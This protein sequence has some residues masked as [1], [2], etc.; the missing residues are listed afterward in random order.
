MVRNA[1]SSENF[2][3]YILENPVGNECVIKY[4]N[5]NATKLEGSILDI[6]GRTIKRIVLSNLN[7]GAGRFEIPVSN[8]VSGN[9][10]VKLTTS[11]H[12]NVI[13]RLLKK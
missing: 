1:S 10:I 4:N 8:L 9:Y 5:L 6:Y 2:S 13:L 11:T 7:T 3:A 12:T